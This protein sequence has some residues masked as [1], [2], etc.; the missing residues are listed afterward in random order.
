MF[1]D[2]VFFYH[3]IYRGATLLNFLKNLVSF[4]NL[5]HIRCPICMSQTIGVLHALRCCLCIRFLWVPTFDALSGYVLLVSFFQFN[6]LW[7]CNLKFISSIWFALLSEL[8]CYNFGVWANSW[9]LKI[10]AHGVCCRIT[11]WVVCSLHGQIRPFFQLF[12]L[13]FRFCFL[14]LL[15]PCVVGCLLLLFLAVCRAVCS[16]C[17]WVWLAI[18]CM[19]S[20]SVSE[21]V[22]QI[23]RTKS[24]SRDM[25]QKLVHARGRHTCLPSQDATAEHEQESWEEHWEE[26]GANAQEKEICC[27][28]E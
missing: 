17:C 21:A 7:I 23:A 18:I 5:I 4:L 20:G 25:T 12:F 26:R 1:Y 15:L 11:N 24:S 14:L 27:L 2:L 9:Q 3:P 28:S 13:L 6:G 16:Q 22:R 8:E 19:S 10:R